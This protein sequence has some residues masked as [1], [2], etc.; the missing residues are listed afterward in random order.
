MAVPDPVRAER[1]FT[2]EL[3]PSLSLLSRFLDVF[4]EKK[5]MGVF[6]QDPV[7]SHLFTK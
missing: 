4:V 5:Y 1:Y 6:T 2:A 3:R 7:H